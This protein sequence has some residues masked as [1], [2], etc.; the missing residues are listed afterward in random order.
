[1]IGLL[2]RI[3]IALATGYTLM[4]Y[5]DSMFWARFKPGDTP[6]DLAV[7]WLFYSLV[8]YAFLATVAVFR[9]SGLWATFLAGALYGSLVEGVIVQTMYDAFPLLGLA[10]I[11]LTAIPL[12]A[13][14]S[15]LSIRLYTGWAVYLCA[16]PLGAGMFV[17]SIWGLLRP[18]GRAKSG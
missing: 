11:P 4:Y 10:A 5:S 6:G 14:A 9:V 12:Y 7:T 13:L 2:K 8:T 3:G 1:M 15:T 17:A 16:T 18:P